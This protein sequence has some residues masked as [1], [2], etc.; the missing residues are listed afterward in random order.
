MRTAQTLRIT[1]ARANCLAI[2]GSFSLF[3]NNFLTVKGSFVATSFFHLRTNLRY[4]ITCSFSAP[5]ISR[6]T[7]F[8]VLLSHL[9]AAGDYSN[10][11]R[12]SCFDSLSPSKYPTNRSTNKGYFTITP[13]SIFRCWAA[14]VKFADVISATLRSITT[15]FPCK[16]DRFS[17]DPER[18][19]GSYNSSG[20][21]VPGQWFSL[22]SRANLATIS[23]ERD[24][25]AC[26]RAMSRHNHTRSSGFSS[27][28]EAS[29]SKI[30]FPW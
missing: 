19:R 14:S 3:D 7:S 28:R 5:L 8:P 23:S 25:S 18:E 26:F 11:Q 20:I 9:L 2:L 24:V 1:H 12:T 4:D 27:I 13:T 17:H 6:S 16:L 10:G 15:H 22:K 30:R 21:R 29:R